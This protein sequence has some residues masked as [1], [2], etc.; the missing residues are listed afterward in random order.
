MSPTVNPR[1]AASLVLIKEDGENFSV[2][3][4]RRPPSS[5]FI[6]DAF[7]FPG[8][9]SDP[10]DRQVQA[11]FPLIPETE[12]AILGLPCSHRA[13][14]LALANTAIRETFEETGIMLARPAPFRAPCPGTWD[15]FESAGLAPDH[16]ALRLLARAITPATSPVRY[17]ARFFLADATRSRGV[18]KDSQ[19]LLDLGWYPIGKALELPIID[20][21]KL[22]LEEAAR[23]GKTGL[24]GGESQPRSTLFVHYRSEKPVIKRDSH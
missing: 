22:V 10:E 16:S 18:A 9:K 20:V 21:T 2:L 14:P 6:P 24:I 13:I 1:D 12:R 4:G 19:E 7:V 8:G 11:P 5:S 15:Y 17:H 3:M 23:W